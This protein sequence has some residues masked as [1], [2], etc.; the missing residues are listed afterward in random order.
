MKKFSLIIMLLCSILLIL[1]N[2]AFAQNLDTKEDSKDNIV[3]TQ[4][5]YIAA[6]TSFAVYNDKLG[7]LANDILTKYGWQTKRITEK[8]ANSD[9]K[10]LLAS[11]Q[12]AEEPAYFLSICGTSSWSD[13]KT[14]FNVQSVVFE[15][16]NTQEFVNSLQSKDDDKTKPRVHKGF[17]QYVQDGFFTKPQ[18][19][20]DKMPLGEFLAEKLKQ[21]PDTKLYI[22]GHSLG[23]AV[24]EVLAA[25]LL[26]MG[27]KTEQLKIITFGA[28]AVGNQ[29]F[30]DEFEPKM[31]LTRITI[32]GDPV[33]NL[34]QIANDHLIQ[35][36]QNTIWNLPWSEDD[37]FAHGMLLYFDGAMRQ[38]YDAK[39]M[40]QMQKEKQTADY[41]INITFDFP[42]EL[43]ADEFYITSA[44]ADKLQMEQ[45]NI[46]FI[47]DNKQ[48][49]A[50]AKQYQA[51]YVVFYRYEAKLLKN[52]PSNKRYYVNCTKYIYNIEGKFI[53]A[54]SA[55]TD[56]NDM[57]VVQAALYTNYKLEK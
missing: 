52:N 18:A 55:S 12:M 21:N 23:G 33:K 1:C 20:C 46:I 51:K 29:A 4:M 40:Q 48:I 6:W 10:M 47:N 5:Q 8:I 25:R 38:Y 34:A 42:S 7:T 44:V 15:G 22:T 31:D 35:F 56:T 45:K 11:K 26:S 13:V 27:V 16:T 3:D 49:F 24:A 53:K 36:K 54:S 17:A 14:D 43:Q 39:N 37:K 28:P 41:A 9:V 32:K 2:M 57:T 19:D 50:Q 30:V